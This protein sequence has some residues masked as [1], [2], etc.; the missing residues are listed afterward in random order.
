MFSREHKICRNSILHLQRSSR[1]RNNREYQFWHHLPKIQWSIQYNSI[2]NQNMM[3]N[4]SWF[5]IYSVFGHCVC[6]CSAVDLCTLC[7][8]VTAQVNMYI[9]WSIHTM[10]WSLYQ[11]LL[12]LDY[13]RY[14]YI[15]LIFFQA[16]DFVY[17]LVFVD[18]GNKQR[19]CQFLTCFNLLVPFNILLE[20]KAC[21]VAFS[22]YCMLYWSLSVFSGG[23]AWNNMQFLYF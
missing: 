10:D 9:D 14:C 17:M 23:K 22:I 21:C 8:V 1:G 19:P 11:G 20:I 16:L 3:T 4:F 7:N 6:T 5:Y 15:K 13:T 12:L 2:L 18:V